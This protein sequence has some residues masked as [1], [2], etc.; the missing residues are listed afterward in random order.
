MIKSTLKYIGKDGLSS[1]ENSSS[2]TKNINHKSFNSGYSEKNRLF[3]KNNLNL[4]NQA[5]DKT[6]RNELRSGQNRLLQFNEE[7]GYKGDK[8]AN[9]LKHKKSKKKKQLKKRKIKN[10]DI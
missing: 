1:D 6:N 9:K 7:E 10:R 3:G 8:G 5:K 2:L 4:L